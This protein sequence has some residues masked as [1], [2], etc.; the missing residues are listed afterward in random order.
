MAQTRKSLFTAGMLAL[1]SLAF[2]TASPL[3][4]QPLG[5]ISPKPIELSQHKTLACPGG[6]FVFGQI[7]DD[8]KDQFMLDTI[9]GRLWRIAESGEVGT[10]LRSVPYRQEN[11]SYSP[12]PEDLSEPNPKKTPKE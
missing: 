12:L 2:F 5:A 8:S 10:F 1:T 4:G 7:S 9:T 11:G 3:W 6:R